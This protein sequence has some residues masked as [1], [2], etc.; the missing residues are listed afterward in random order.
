MNKNVLEYGIRKALISSAFGVE[1]G[2]E[3]VDAYL[4]IVAY[5]RE[6]LPEEIGSINGIKIDTEDFMTFEEIFNHFD[7]ERK[8]ASF[9]SKI[10]WNKYQLETGYKKP[11]VQLD[12]EKDYDAA[13]KW[14]SDEEVLVDAAVR[15]IFN[16]SKGT[17]TVSFLNDIAEL[18]GEEDLIPLSIGEMQHCHCG[19]EYM[20]DLMS[21][22][23]ESFK[24]ISGMR[25]DLARS[26]ITP[27]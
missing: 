22:Y 17:D 19:Y 20:S 8:F 3:L 6:V 27:E 13:L 26:F 23:H 11:S 14:L 21:R 10:L 2:D 25:Y 9:M 15:S 5:K 4:Q 24:L 18:N 7:Y 12:Y 1:G 16:L